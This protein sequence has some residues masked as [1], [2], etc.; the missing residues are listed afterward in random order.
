M[1]I[2]VTPEEVL[3][4][5]P[6]TGQPPCEAVANAHLRLP[7]YF[8]DFIKWAVETGGTAFTNAFL[9]EIW[10]SGAFL[11]SA[12][13]NLD[14]GSSGSKW[15]LC[16]GHTVP[17]ANYPELFALIGTTYGPA[18]AGNFT[19]PDFRGNFPLPVSA[20]HTLGSTGGA[21]TV[22]LVAANIPA[23]THTITI[24]TDNA[25][26]DNAQGLA[27]QGDLA[28]PAP[29][30]QNFTSSTGTGLSGTA[31]DNM[32]PFLTFGYVYIKT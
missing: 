18:A 23:H 22:A 16:D 4:A 12:A 8:Y 5:L 30:T 25:G 32:P 13:S 20:S 1:S 24:P 29:T 26:A 10:P 6:Q 19:L 11:M 17:Q 28:G 14:T 9:R 21:E 7:R 15:L 27:A 3:A 2:P 31:H